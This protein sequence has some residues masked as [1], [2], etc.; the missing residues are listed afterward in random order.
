[1]T[2]PKKLRSILE[3]SGEERFEYFIR[4]VTDFSEVW[5]LFDNGW[6]TS[7]DKSGGTAIPFWP[8]KDFARLCASETWK[9]YAP[10][11][12]GI[13]DFLDKWLPGMEKDGSLAA[14]FPT[15]TDKSV[16]IEP[17][18]L[19]SLLKKEMEQHE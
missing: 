8:E 3:K 7:S 10:R 12:I 5:G 1:M 13:E 15:P 14:V 9:N 6:A 4:K 11:K 2:H 17:N 16:F 19:G 18:R